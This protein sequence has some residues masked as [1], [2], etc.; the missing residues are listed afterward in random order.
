M[1]V[2]CIPLRY[3][4]VRY[5]Y[6]TY[7]TQIRRLVHSPKSS[8]FLCSVHLENPI[9]AIYLQFIQIYSVQ[10]LLLNRVLL[11]AQ[12][13]TKIARATKKLRHR[14]THARTQDLAAITQGS[15]VLMSS[16]ISASA[17][18]IIFP[19]LCP[20]RA[21]ITLMETQILFFPVAAFDNICMEKQKYKSTRQ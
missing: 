18:Y 20:A 6:E 19:S 4:V 10:K 8:N 13:L 14:R 2:L 11:C 1:Y 21:E 12:I 17:R 15:Q 3:L 9:L 7:H 5:K 16:V